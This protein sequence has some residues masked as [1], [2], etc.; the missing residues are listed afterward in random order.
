MIEF[1]K[2]TLDSTEIIRPYLM[3]S[4]NR[5]CDF[6]VGGTVMWREAFDMQYD[7]YDGALYIKMRLQDGRT[8]FTFPLGKPFKE[9]HK[10]L[11]EYCSHTWDKLVFATASA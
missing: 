6:S 11:L 9:T 3:Q 5:L 8:A 1:K 4:K 2:M 10:K 7:V